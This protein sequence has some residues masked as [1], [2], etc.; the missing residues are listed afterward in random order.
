MIEFAPRSPFLVYDE[1]W[2]YMATCTHNNKYDWYGVKDD[3]TITN[4]SSGKISIIPVRD[5]Q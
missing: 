2:L 3:Q 5:K 1:A 4:N